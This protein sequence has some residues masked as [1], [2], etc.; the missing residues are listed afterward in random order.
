MKWKNILIQ[1]VERLITFQ[2]VSVNEGQRERRNWCSFLLWQFF[3]ELASCC[4][5]EY[6]LWETNNMLHDVVNGIFLFK[7][8]F[9]LLLEWIEICILLSLKWSFYRS[10][11]L[12][13]LSVSFER[14]FVSKKRLS[15]CIFGDE[16]TTIFQ[17]LTLIT[18][19]Q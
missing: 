1:E 14:G 12:F 16:M 4:I 5:R 7:W 15:F 10:L 9:F 11:I 17:T 8:A 19:R 18:Y 3:V 13:L 6:Q 2:L